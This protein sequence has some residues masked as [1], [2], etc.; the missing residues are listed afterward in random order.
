ML[1]HV[2][3][4]ACRSTSVEQFTNNY[5]LNTIVEGLRLQTSQPV[6]VTNPPQMIPFALQIV[7]CWFNDAE[8]DERGRQR[9]TLQNPAGDTLIQH[10]VELAVPARA[11]FRTTGRVPGIPYTGNGVYWFNVS[12][13]KGDSWETV[14]RVPL[15]VE[16]LARQPEAAPAGAT[17]SPAANPTPAAQ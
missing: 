10:E 8:V 16:I 15:V 5:S 14:A 12:L 2:Y 13:Q 6:S 9:M 7:T 1:H 11:N 17:A 3:S 4:V